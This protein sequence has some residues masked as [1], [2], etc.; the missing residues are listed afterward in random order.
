[1]S[2]IAARDWTYEVVTDSSATDTLLAEERIVVVLSTLTVVSV[3]LLLLLLLLVHEVSVDAVSATLG[4]MVEAVIET[5]VESGVEVTAKG[6]SEAM[7]P[8]A[9]R[10]TASSSLAVMPLKPSRYDIRPPICSSR[11]TS[12]I[13]GASPIS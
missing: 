4:A 6:S 5:E 1:M 9:M 2:L 13:R 3:S 10:M 8:R 7:T 12:W 11:A